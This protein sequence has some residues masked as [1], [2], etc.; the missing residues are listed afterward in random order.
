MDGGGW[1]IGTELKL[2][3]FPREFTV[4]ETGTKDLL[5]LHPLQDQEVALWKDYSKKNLGALSF[6]QQ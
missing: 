1:R 6:S 3:C 4:Q 5:I 2:S